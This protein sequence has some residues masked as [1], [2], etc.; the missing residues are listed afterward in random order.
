VEKNRRWLT[1]GKR[2]PAPQAR[3]WA[4]TNWYGDGIGTVMRTRTSGLRILMLVAEVPFTWDRHG[5]GDGA[6]AS[7]PVFPRGNLRAHGGAGCSY[8]IPALGAVS[9]L[10]L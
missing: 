10:R 4:L 9:F 2:K 8:F 6:T 5:D 3:L 7:L 1:A